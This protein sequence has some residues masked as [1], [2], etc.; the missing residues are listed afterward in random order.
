[1]VAGRLQVGFRLLGVALCWCGNSLMVIGAIS[2]SYG[3]TN[4][5][6]SKGLLWPF[7]GMVNS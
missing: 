6:T 2:T 5:V 1:M 7:G 4:G 3:T